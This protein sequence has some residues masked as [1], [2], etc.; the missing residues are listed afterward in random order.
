MSFPLSYAR[1]RVF[2]PAT[3]PASVRRFYAQDMAH[4]DAL[5]AAHFPSTGPGSH[6]R[7][8][9]FD[10]EYTGRKHSD[11]AIRPM[12]I[13]LPRTQDHFI[14]LLTIARDGVVI[15]FDLLVLAGVPARLIEMLRDPN[16]I[17]VGVELK[18]DS[19]L[20]LR[21]FAVPVHNGWEI[22]QLWKSM[23]PSI[24]VAPLTTHISLDDMARIVLGVKVDKLQ[25]TSDWSAPALSV[26]QI[27]YSYLDA[28]ILVPI[29]HVVL[30]EYEM[31]V[32]P[33]FTASSFS[34]NADFVVDGAIVPPG[35]QTLGSDIRVW[36]V[37]DVV[38]SGGGDWTPR[39]A[40]LDRYNASIYTSLLL[41]LL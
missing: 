23:H 34:F 3:L 27:E 11:V 21:H 12:S 22:S 38:P 33:H 1:S 37:G 19:I 25:Q 18:G 15:A 20:L 5:L 13:P 39:H 29:M 40:V 31:G 7:V 26:E 30:H 10:V 41:F 28:Y 32:W 4:T 14:R 24:E 9:A 35:P 16:I 36:G 8:L 6:F 17:K 2:N